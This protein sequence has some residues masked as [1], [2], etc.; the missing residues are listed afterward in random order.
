[1]TESGSPTSHVAR[2]STVNHARRISFAGK[3]AS[4]SDPRGDNIDEYDDGKDGDD[5]ADF[6]DDFDDFEEGGEDAE[7]GDFDGGFQEAETVPI[8]QKQLLPTIA[9][10]FV[11]RSTIHKVHRRRGQS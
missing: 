6:G 8:H 11:S 9:T 1:M 4:S 10:S 2:S 3:K 5:D 7:F